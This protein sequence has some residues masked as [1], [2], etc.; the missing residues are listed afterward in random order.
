MEPAKLE[1]F[2]VNVLAS[3][4]CRWT[5]LV[6]PFVVPS[7]A[8][9]KCYLT[10]TTG[11]VAW[12]VETREPVFAA[13]GNSAVLCAP[14]KSQSCCNS[15]EHRALLCGVC[16]CGLCLNNLQACIFLHIYGC[17]CQCG[18]LQAGT[19]FMPSCLHIHTQTCRLLYDIARQL[20]FSSL[21]I[22]PPLSMNEGFVWFFLQLSAVH[23]YP[24][25]ALRFLA[26]TRGWVFFHLSLTEEIIS[27]WERLGEERQTN[28]SY[29]W[30]RPRRT[31]QTVLVPT[32]PGCCQNFVST[33][34]CCSTKG[35]HKR[36]W[37][38]QW[39][40]Q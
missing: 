27:D 22:T 15:Q 28:I 3:L 12:L 8:P 10:T 17:S 13:E 34:F 26:S 37:L 30:T 40:I 38:L 14:F 16:V 25:F 19:V 7:L 33:T 4:F 32:G 21:S 23:C 24:G 11:A 31:L 29:L 35:S 5:K 36:L 6:C 2:G 39:D 9:S 20:F 1:W 18:F